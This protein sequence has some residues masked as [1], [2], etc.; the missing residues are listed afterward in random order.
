MLHYY[1]GLLY[2]NAKQQDPPVFQVSNPGEAVSFRFIA[3]NLYTALTFTA[4]IL[5]GPL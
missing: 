4:T 3:I 2:T 1:Y 5:C